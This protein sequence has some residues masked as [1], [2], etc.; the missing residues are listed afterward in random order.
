MIEILSMMV[1]ATE[2]K[3]LTYLVDEA[4]RLKNIGDPDAIEQWLDC[5]R[6]TQSS[7]ALG[8]IFT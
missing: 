1:Y 6:G 5:L 7:R 2:Q 3:V 4:E 8:L